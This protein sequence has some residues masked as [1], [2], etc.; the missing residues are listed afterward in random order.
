ML[1]RIGGAILAALAVGLGIYTIVSSESWWVT[2]ILAF[3]ALI[4]F[5]F[6]LLPG[7]KETAEPEQPTRTFKGDLDGSKIDKVWSDADILVDG[8]ARN[9]Q[10][11]DITHR[12]DR[13]QD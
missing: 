4:G 1:P 6:M 8:N 3:V 12:T 11:S 10:I 13:S 2:A 5:F 7:E 9:A